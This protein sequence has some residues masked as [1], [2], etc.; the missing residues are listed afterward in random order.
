MLR[1]KPW[2]EPQVRQVLLA[3]E[4]GEDGEPDAVDSNSS[5]SEKRSIQ[6]SNATWSRPSGMTRLRSRKGSAL[7][8]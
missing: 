3:G 6:S 5:D 1:L 7:M 2:S 8:V 4:D